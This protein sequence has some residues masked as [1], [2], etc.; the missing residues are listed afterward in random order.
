MNSEM[1]FDRFP[2]LETALA[3]IGAPFLPASPSR[4]S[5]R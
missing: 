1:T 3:A 2:G 5:C 4:T